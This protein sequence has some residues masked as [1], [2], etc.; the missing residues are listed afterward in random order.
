MLYSFLFDLVSSFWISVAGPSPTYLLSRLINKVRSAIIFC[1]WAGAKLSFASS[2]WSLWETRGSI[3][4]CMSVVME[5]SP[6]CRSLMPIKKQLSLV[7]VV[8]KISSCDGFGSV[9]SF[10]LS[11]SRSLVVFMLPRH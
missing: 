5:I 11:V 1:D 8:R 10:N 9:L 4:D 2:C 3:I 7:C 6:L